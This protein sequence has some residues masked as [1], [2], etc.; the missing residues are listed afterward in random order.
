MLVGITSAAEQCPAVG[1]P[2]A[3]RCDEAV[4]GDDLTRNAVV[5]EA[6]GP[7]AARF[8]ASQSLHLLVLFLEMWGSF[9]DGTV[10]QCGCLRR[11]PLPGDYVN[12][13]LHVSLV[14]PGFLS[15]DVTVRLNIPFRYSL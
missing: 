11:L 8:E 13:Q 12:G 15:G 5:V 6:G 2:V 1:S 14:C 10:F 3:L 4:V 7:F 9:W